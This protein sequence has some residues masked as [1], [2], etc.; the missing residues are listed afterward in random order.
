[1]SIHS[2]LNLERHG[3]SIPILENAIHSNTARL[4]QLEISVPPRTRVDA[5]Y[6][7][8]A[9]RVHYQMARLQ[10]IVDNLLAEN[11]SLLS[12]VRRLLGDQ[13]HPQS[14]PQSD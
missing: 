7:G 12:D 3:L 5:T 4:N 14:P 11:L 1:M 8:D 10:A 13:K 6:I 9:S 2:C